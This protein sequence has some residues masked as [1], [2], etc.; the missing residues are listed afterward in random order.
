VT[1]SNDVV[2]SWWSEQRIRASGSR[3]SKSWN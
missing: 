3:G 1:R 2:S